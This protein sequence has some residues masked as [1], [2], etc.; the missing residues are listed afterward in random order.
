[1]CLHEAAPLVVVKSRLT[2]SRKQAGC[3]AHVLCTSFP[4][5]CLG[6]LQAGCTYGLPWLVVRPGDIPTSLIIAPSFHIMNSRSKNMAM[7]QVLYFRLK[8]IA[9]FWPDINACGSHTRAL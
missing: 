5:S 8:T 7:A 3:A 4:L 6:C 2:G 1:M 9:M